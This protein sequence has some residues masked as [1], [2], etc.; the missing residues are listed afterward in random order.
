MNRTLK[1]IRTSVNWGGRQAIR[2]SVNWG[3]RSLNVLLAASLV[4]ASFT[5]IGPLPAP[6]VARAQPILLQMAAE[7]PDQTVSVIVQKAA[8]GASVEQLVAALGG[9][10]TKD[11]HIINAFAAE[12][13][14]GDA[15]QLARAD[16]V[17]W[18]SLD[19]PVQSAG[20][21]SARF[22]TWATKLGT[23]VANGFTNVNNTLGLVGPNQ[24]YASASRVKSAFAGFQPEYTPGMAIQKI[25][26]ALRL[27]TAKTLGSSEVIKIT[28]Y[29]G[30][31]ALSTYSLAPATV[32]AYVGAA[33]ANT[34]RV[35]ITS[36][37]AWTWSDFTSL[38]IAINQSALSTKSTVY[39]D[40]VGL[41]IHAIPGSDATTPLSFTSSSDDSPVNDSVLANVFPKV[42]RANTAWNTAPYY[43]GSGVTIA[44]VDS[45]TFKTNALG[46]RLIGEVNFNSTEH[47]TADQYG[48]GTFVS[49]VIGDDGSDSGGQ[50]TGTAPR[51]NI[52]GVRIADDY[53]MGTE[54]DVV[55][56]LQWIY[57]NKSAYNI[58]VVN[59]SLNASTW[60]SY[61]TSPLDAAAEIL[62]FNGIVVVV[63][64]GNN[65][66]ATLYPPANDPFVITVGA[67]NDMNTASLT[68]DVIASF[69]AYG[70]DEA[71]QAKPDLVAPGSNIIA[72]LPDTTRLTISVQHPENR[73]NAYYFRMSGTSM[74]APMVAGGA[75]ILL[76]KEPGL[77]PDQVKYRLKATAN[78]S[79]PGYL[80]A[81]TGAGYLDVYAAITG[82]T[83]QSANTGLQA[84]QLLWS[85]SDP[86][87]WGSVNWNSVN[88]NSVNWNSVNWNSVNWNSVN[89]NS[90]YWGP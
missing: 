36:A 37:R 7:Q 62:W 41:Y 13:K 76:Q 67:T 88:W 44:V 35:D 81:K 56:A 71:G 22:Y 30:G 86:I 73:V 50:Y 40:A 75:A 65:G 33:A 8:M 47:T 20:L 69:S 16:G 3:G 66:T 89:W 82:A 27:Y 19:G 31:A 68:D 46:S 12:M 51:V 38:Q 60:Q 6:V 14:A 77:T 64:A 25:E 23:A 58:K 55:D 72:F 61:H 87:T 11:L 43:Q 17:R 90:D 57:N 59:L 10:V 9:T 24:T 1:S 5:L 70:V 45:G 80:A 83:T 2:K 29:V 74:S 85:G 49:G 63:S 79:W 4:L 54:S 26:V 28:P 32:N 48:H 21:S 52:V 15:A 34:V 53:G 18:V 39:Y 42:I 84:S 78:K